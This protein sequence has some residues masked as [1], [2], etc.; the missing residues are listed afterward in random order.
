[1]SEAIRTDPRVA[2]RQARV[3]EILDA[4]WRIARAEGLA[5]VSLHE[6]ARQVGLR[7][8]SLYGYFPSKAGLYDAMFAQAYRALIDE[9]AAAPVASDPRRRVVDV[10]RVIL[11]FNAA[12]A[13]RQQLLFHRT[14]PGFTPSAES[15]A[16]ARQFLD[17]IV[18]LLH[19]AGVTKA[20]DV[21]IYTAFVAGLGA[22]QI[23]NDP[24]GNRWT[25]RLDVVLAMFF[26]HV[27][28]KEA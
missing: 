13:A 25:K 20:A 2:R 18:D 24:G 17:G 6:V 19:D 9:V 11:Q 27:D 5:A 22:Q 16:L 23:A 1:M 4:A 12:D 3:A 8:P 10:S 21:D 28:A 7:Q 14:I 15:Y 26:A